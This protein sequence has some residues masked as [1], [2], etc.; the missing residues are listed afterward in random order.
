[1][2]KKE[3]LVDEI[4]LLIGLPTPNMSHG[5]REPRVLFTEA[6][7]RLGLSESGLNTKQDIA[8]YIVTISG[9]SWTPSC[10]SRGGTVTLEGL[11]Q[12]K[13]AIQLLLNN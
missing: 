5:S 2:T 4:A 1:M 3:V 8:E 7:V 9:L 13:N 10:W 6:L 11:T 12:L